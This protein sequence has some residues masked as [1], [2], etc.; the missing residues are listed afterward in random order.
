MQQLDA[1]SHRRHSLSCH[2]PPQSGPPSCDRSAVCHREESFCRLRLPSKFHLGGPLLRA[3]TNRGVIWQRGTFFPSPTN[4]QPLTNNYPDRNRSTGYIFPTVDRERYCRPV[5]SRESVWQRHILPA[6]HFTASRYCSWFWRE[7]PH[8][9]K[10]VQVGYREVEPVGQ[11]IDGGGV[12]IRSGET[13]AKRL[14]HSRVCDVERRKNPGFARH[15]EPFQFP[16]DRENVGIVPCGK[17]AQYRAAR[18]IDGEKYVIAVACHISNCRIRR[19][20]QAVGMFA[21]GQ[22][23][24]ADPGIFRG[25]KTASSFFD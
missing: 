13:I 25:S 20:S 6:A 2:G 23:I 24:E 16:V 3:V 14:R 10:T 12:R 8:D 19:E 22:R 15:V 17:A 11:C 7:F 1:A 18:E 4:I 9:G 21:A 5:F